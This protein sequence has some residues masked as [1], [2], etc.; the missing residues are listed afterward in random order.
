MADKWD[1]NVADRL[2]RLPP[3]LFGQLNKLKYEKRRDGV[4]IIDLGGGELLRCYT[5]DT[6]KEDDFT[7]S[8]GIID[9]WS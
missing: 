9:H 5:D 6:E 3:Y 7:L 2:L 1:I 4:D 8:K